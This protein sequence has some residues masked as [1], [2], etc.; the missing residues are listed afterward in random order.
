MKRGAF[1]D[2]DGVINRKPAEGEYVT[3]WE[4]ME[5]LPG[6]PDAIA[7]LTQAGYCVLA[8]SNQRCVA[9]GLLKVSELES[10][11]ERLCKVLEDKGAH[12][13]R[14]Y[15]CPH[16]NHPP[17]GCRKPAPGMLLAAAREHGIDLRNSWMFGDSDVDMQAGRSAGCRTIRIGDN[18]GKNTSNADRFAPTLLEAV[19]QILKLD[20]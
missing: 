8:V 20:C 5:I 11:H 6:V 1:L 18:Y 7:L 13:T 3:R 14:I 16:D 10:M 9:K 19:H 4:E 15:Y 17:C 12:I 2:R